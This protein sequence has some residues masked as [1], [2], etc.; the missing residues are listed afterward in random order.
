MKNILLILAAILLLDNNPV[1][2]Q[3]ATL[4]PYGIKSGI[5]EYP[6]SGDKVGK[7]TLYFD[8]YGLKSAMYTDAVERGEK[9]KGWVV[10]SGDFQ[11]IWDDERSSEGMKL[12]NPVIDWIN[13]ASEGDI[14]SFAESMYSK[15]G[16]EISGSEN[17]LGKECRVFKGKTGKVL[18]W[19]GILMLLD[20][21]MMGSNSC[22]E[23]ID[24][25]INLPVESKYFIIPKDIKFSEMPMF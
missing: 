17:L 13:S 15:M 2:S 24:I 19:N 25:K 1:K 12:K 10:T 14:E 16:M 6:Y 9:R 21:K 18:I 4:K 3:E 22:Q 20:M 11:Y 7:G 23:A 5:I 8:D